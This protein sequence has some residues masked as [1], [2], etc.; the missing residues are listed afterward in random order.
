[1]NIQKPNTIIFRTKIDPEIKHTKT[2]KK[3]RTKTQY[4][5]ISNKNKSVNKIQIKY[6]ITHTNEHTKT[7]YKNMSNKKTIRKYKNTKTHTN[8]RTKAQ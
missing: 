2:N 3:K 7:K 4:K 8:E 6:T 5:H 1:M